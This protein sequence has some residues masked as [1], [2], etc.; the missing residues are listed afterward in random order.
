MEWAVR[1]EKTDRVM[2]QFALVGVLAAVLAVGCAE[3]QKAMD[4]AAK[5][6]AAAAQETQQPAPAESKA[7]EQP[8]PTPPPP[9]GKVAPRTAGKE[10]FQGHYLSVWLDGQR[11]SETDKTAGSERIW[12]V[13][14]CSATPTVRFQYD[15]RHLGDFREAAVVINPIKAGKADPTDL[16][17]DPQAGAELKPDQ[18]FQLGPFQHIAGGKLTQHPALPPGRYS[19]KVQVNGTHTWDRQTIHVTAK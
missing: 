15:T 9:R 19:I 10:E 13:S 2:K 3:M 18:R 12:S 11:T 14:S 17:Q 8:T 1:T 7:P 6:A 4:E 16:W 5:R